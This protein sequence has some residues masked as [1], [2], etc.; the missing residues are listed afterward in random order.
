MA[1]A[2][3]QLELVTDEETFRVARNQID[4]LA[5]EPIRIL[6]LVDHDRT[7]AEPLTLADRVVV[8]QEIARA[9]LQILEVE[10]GL[11]VL[12]LLIRNR[13]LRQEVL[14]QISVGSRELV[15]RRLLDR[16]AR[17][18]VRGGALSACMKAREVEE[19]VGAHVALE[20]HESL[21]RSLALRVAGRAVV[22]QTLRGLA[23]VFRTRFEARTL[24]ELQHELASR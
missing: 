19:P 10:R 11:S 14:E 3:D 13:E 22:R 24:T 15:Q 12:A 20:Q 4:Q 8:A 21:P 6:K 9:Q 5:L 1:E 17:L 23:Q 18:V 7:E 2:V 16:S